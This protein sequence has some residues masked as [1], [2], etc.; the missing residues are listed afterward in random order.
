LWQKETTWWTCELPKIAEIEKQ[1]LNTREVAHRFL[2][3][4]LFNTWVFNFGN[5]WLFRILA[6]LRR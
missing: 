1:K 5:L 2:E 6:I 4:F 3:I